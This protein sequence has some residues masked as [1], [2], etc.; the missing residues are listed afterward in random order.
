[1]I[2]QLYRELAS[3]RRCSMLGNYGSDSKLSAPGCEPLN[4]RF[5]PVAMEFHWSPDVR[6]SW[7][8]LMFEPKDCMARLRKC[9]VVPRVENG[10]HDGPLQGAI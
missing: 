6:F 1:M 3:A 5:D 8:E 7:N 9:R 2:V 4:V 10:A